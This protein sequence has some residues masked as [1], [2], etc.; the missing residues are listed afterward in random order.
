MHILRLTQ[1]L[2]QLEI[3]FVHIVSKATLFQL[4]FLL[5]LLD[6]LFVLAGGKLLHVL[7]LISLQH[8]NLGLLVVL[9]WVVKS[10]VFGCVYCHLLLLL[11][12]LLDHPLTHYNFLLHSS[13]DL[14]FCCR[15]ISM[16][17][18]SWISV[19]GL[20]ALLLHGCIVG[21]LAN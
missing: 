5:L 20:H 6:E 10:V 1:D 12:L 8:L 16:L 3:L 9:H 17:A 11:L 15:I 13:L 14:Y 2:L 21:R 18:C 19:C 7:T 4:F